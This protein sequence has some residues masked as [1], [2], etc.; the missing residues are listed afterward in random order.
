MEDNKM[1]TNWN[2][3]IENK[4]MKS[5]KEIYNELLNR[6]IKDIMFDEYTLELS[7]KGIGD[8][9]FD[10]EAKS[11]SLRSI[12]IV[13]HKMNRIDKIRITILCQRSNKA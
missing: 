12:G 2:T 8:V 13:Y 6:G 1:T 4:S 3:I 11:I 7:R 5:M 10:E 9:K